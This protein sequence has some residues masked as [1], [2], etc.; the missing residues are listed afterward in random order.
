M[1]LVP[2]IPHYRIRL[3]VK[4]EDKKEILLVQRG[5]LHIKGE[6]QSMV[7]RLWRN[8]VAVVIRESGF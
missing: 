2:I 5:S 6:K 3:K 4:E 7:Q 8:A 1:N